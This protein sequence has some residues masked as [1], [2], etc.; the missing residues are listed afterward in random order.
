MHG[1]FIFVLKMNIE[2]LGCFLSGSSAGLF[3]GVKRII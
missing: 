2:N 3:E 1:V